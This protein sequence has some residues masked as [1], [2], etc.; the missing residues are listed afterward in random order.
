M[1]RKPSSNTNGARS[2]TKQPASKRTA[3]TTA[4]ISAGLQPQSGKSAVPQTY[5]SMIE[6]AASVKLSESVDID[7]AFEVA[8]PNAPRWDYGIGVEDGQQERAYW[9]E[10]H[11]AS[12]TGEVERMLK[13]I[14]WLKGKLKQHEFSGLDK[15]TKATQATGQTAFIWT[16][17]G[18]NR[19]PRD[20][21]LA[22]RLSHE[23][24]S[25]P[26]RKVEL[27]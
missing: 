1:T 2:T 16:Y 26:C 4:A 27:K 3:F 18:D 15:L 20:S 12:S 14:A 22:R 5:R 19:I 17:S 21:Q 8:E 7:A 13:K 23:G 24:L 10:P 6:T 25:M 9:L 11:P